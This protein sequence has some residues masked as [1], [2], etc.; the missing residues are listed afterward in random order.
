ME[1]VNRRTVAIAAAGLLGRRVRLFA[2]LI[3]A[4]ARIS[5]LAVPP[6]ACH[7]A[8]T[9]GLRMYLVVIRRSYFSRGN[10]SLRGSLRALTL[11]ARQYS[12]SVE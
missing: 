11:C 2:F 10:L 6:S 7:A 5:L 8:G 12:R 9:D 1:I 4:G 3:Q